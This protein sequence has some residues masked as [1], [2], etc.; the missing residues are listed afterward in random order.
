MESSEETDSETVQRSVDK[1]KG[2]KTVVRITN[3]EISK[4]RHNNI[5]FADL[6]KVLALIRGNYMEKSKRKRGP[7]CNIKH[8][9]FLSTSENIDTV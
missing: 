2:W 9:F 3:A 4:S 7:C 5:A 6:E 1:G 8:E